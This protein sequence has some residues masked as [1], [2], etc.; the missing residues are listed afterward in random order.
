MQADVVLSN[1][2]VGDDGLT[3]VA[4]LQK[5]KPGEPNP[6][7]VGREGVV[8]YDAGWRSCLS[9]DIDEAVKK[10]APNSFLPALNPLR[11]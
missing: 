9:A 2:T 3:K 6:Y 7:V 4:A 1:H 5:R 8:R 10:A 11:P